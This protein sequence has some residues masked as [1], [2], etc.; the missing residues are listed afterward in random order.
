[1]E[2]L[3]VRLRE[4]AAPAQ[5]AVF[6]EDGR[7]MRQADTGPLEDAAPLAAGRR[8]VVLVP[9]AEAVLTETTLPKASPARL[10]KMLPFSLEDTLAEDVE[11]LAFAVGA[12]QESGAV[13]VAVVSR[14]RLE[15]WLE[16]ISAAGLVPHALHSDA[17]GVPDTPATLT[18]IVEDDRIYGRAPGR[19][20][21]VFEGLNL[22]QVVDVVDGERE[23]KH[24]IVYV[25]EAGRARHADELRELGELIESTQVKLMAD[26]A[27]YRLGATLTVQP[28]TN[29][30]QGE[31]APKS[32]VGALLKPWRAAAGLLLGLVLVSIA[33]QAAEYFSLRAQSEAL[34]VRLGEVC[35]QELSVSL[36]E[37][38]Q[39]VRQRLSEAGM[40]TSGAGFLTAMAAIAEARATGSRV[41][42]LDYSGGRLLLEIS[43]Q[44]VSSLDAFERDAERSGVF[45]DV[46]VQSLSSARDGETQQARVELI[47]GGANR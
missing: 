24:A 19:P 40:L 36:N 25:D 39:V 44:D 27:L 45:S 4:D 14:A 30:L 8:I 20:A 18:L 43:V 11:Q 9:G 15:S 10:R 31:Y 12:R 17:D 1:V 13:A 38:E 47:A 5:W 2:H 26:G 34:E 41:S 16:R 37:C 32:H 23:L 3:V 22:R 42:A 46:R 28:G 33:A 21:F 29:L 7:V 35:Q 6:D